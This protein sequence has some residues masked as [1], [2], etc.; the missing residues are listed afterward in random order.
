M[1][2]YKIVVLGSMGAGKS[3]LVRT[4]AEGG[5]VDTDV[6][7]TDAASD[8]LATTVAMDYADLRLPNG[9]RMR[10]YGSPGQQRF[11]FV[12]PVLL[13]GAAGAI[14]LIDGASA[15]ALVQ[16]DAYLDTLR[17]HAAGVPVVLAISRLDLDPDA[18]LAP[19]HA[20]LETRGQRLPV[21]AVDVR[22]RDQVLMLMDVLMGE[23]ETS[24]L[25]GHG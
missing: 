9:E 12:W 1:R 7:N 23:I 20:R 8:K 11:S 10:L 15:Q 2:E 18:D 4:V 5:V 21:L 17:E 25:V 16:F 6:A 3:T 24:E 14:V 19:F 22:E 13:G